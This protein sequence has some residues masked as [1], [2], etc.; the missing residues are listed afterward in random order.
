MG[1][2]EL[3]N[4]R[5]LIEEAIS[6]ADDSKLRYALEGAIGDTR[7]FCWA[8]LRQFERRT[9]YRGLS[10]PQD[11]GLQHADYHML[12]AIGRDTILYVEVIERLLRAIGEPKE[13]PPDERIR[14]GIR[15]ARN[16]LA[17]HREERVLYRRL[18]GKH[19]PHVIETYERL[20]L[21]P[22][23][24]SIDTE[25]TAYSPPSDAT[26]EEIE[27]GY[28]SIGTVG[29]GLLSLGAL[30]TAF[31]QLGC[32]LD[33]LATEYRSSSRSRNDCTTSATPVDQSS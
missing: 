12:L 33:E 1:R 16:L 15:E 13:L 24:G 31:R 3:R 25:I 30:Y 10:T 27:A 26:D 6:S 2:K 28:A 22:P 17:V 21:G 32:D 5:Q 11:V 29:R 23:Q 9:G 8:T 18:T 4:Q 7:S 20:G 19:T 14:Y